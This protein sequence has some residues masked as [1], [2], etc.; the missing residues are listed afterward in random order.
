VPSLEHLLA[1][2]LHALKNTRMHRF[3][4]D[5][6]DGENLIRINRLDIKSG[7][8]RELFEKYG[9]TECM[10][11]YPDHL[12]KSDV[13]QESAASPKLEFPVAPDFVSRPPR[14]ELQ[15]MLKR[16]EENM[17]WRNQRPGEAERRLA[18]KI[19]VEFVL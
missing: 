19:R 8:V 11:K 9:T 14:V 2:K 4:K 15:V 13:L 17:P 6:L 16:I 3:L 18:E 12:P 5:F 1:L 10:K 7:K